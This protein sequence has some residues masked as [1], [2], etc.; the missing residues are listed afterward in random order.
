MIAFKKREVGH[1]GPLGNDAE[2][3][4]LSFCFK[5]FLLLAT[6]VKKCIGTPRVSYVAACYSP[7]KG[8]YP[9]M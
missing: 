7:R 5:F 4:E 3:S 8:K 2:E 1:T 6:N 9:E